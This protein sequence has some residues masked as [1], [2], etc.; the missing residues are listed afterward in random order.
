MK[1]RVA[2][3]IPTL[4]QGGAEKQMALL[5]SHLDRARFDPHVVV[6]TADGPLRDQ[7]V[8]AQVPVHFIAKKGKLDPAAAVRLRATLKK[9]APDIVHTWL[10]A[11]NS[12]GR[13]AAWA[14]GVPIVI[15]GE[16]SVDPW[17]RWWHHAIDRLLLPITDRLVTNTQAVVEF[18]RRHGI[19][20][21][22]FQV[23]PNAVE[24]APG[25]SWTK[26]QVWER[27]GLPPRKKLILSIGRLWPQKGYRDL[28]WAAD[29][30]H[31]AYS[32]LWYV[33]VG[34]GPEFA[35]LQKYRDD[36]GAADSVRFAGHQRDAREW[37]SACDVLWN[38]SRF[39]GQSN[40]ILE[41]M[42]AGKA[43]IASDI[44]G[45]RDLVQHEQ[46]GYLYPLGN[47]Q[48]LCQ[49][50]LKLLDNETLAQQLGD[51]G[52]QRVEQEF[53]LANMVVAHERLYEQLLEQT[54]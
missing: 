17:K 21:E 14:A 47:V 37:I 50:T 22:R 32:D 30:L 34:S 2:H 42:A 48:A 9:L 10:F 44:P 31:N 36:I 6:L 12:Y 51:M 29:M 23:I 4:V 3:V 27:L 38:G 15:A 45:N 39:E 52:K 8:D 41:A 43:V 25:T 16:R 49:M 35:R 26:Q 53:S 18:Y 24:P 33:I 13:V 1:I 40:T 7:L 11:A 5:V 19:P 20:A 54:R 28:I 46:T